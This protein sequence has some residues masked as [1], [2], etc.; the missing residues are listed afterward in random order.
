MAKLYFRYGTMNSGKS[1]EVLRVAHNYEEQGKKAL[2]LTSVVDD[3]FGVGKVV[4]RIGMQKNAIVVDDTLDMVELAQVESPNCILVDEA[5]FL[6]KGQVAQLITIVDDLNIPVIAYGLRADFMGQLFEGSM[7]LIAAADTIEEIKTVCWYCDKKAIMNM[8]CKDGEPI[9]HG[10]QIQI[11]GNESYVPV[12]RKC[13]ASKLKATL[14][15]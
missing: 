12:C 10:E 3:R 1:I 15:G 9:F 6:T 13:Y 7:A 14:N 4:S 5:Q 11:G 8:R 2:L